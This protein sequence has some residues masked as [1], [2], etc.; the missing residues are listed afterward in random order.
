MIFLQALV[1]DVP[2]FRNLYSFGLL[3]KRLVT[4]LNEEPMHRRVQ[5]EWDDI[6]DNRIVKHPS[7]WDATNDAFETEYKEN[8]ELYGAPSTLQDPFT[9]LPARLKMWCQKYHGPGI[10]RFGK[11]P[12]EKIT[13]L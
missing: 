3:K 10:L 9:F 4:C 12:S 7:F 6:F 13:F 1:C 11:C 5:D 8:M 2:L